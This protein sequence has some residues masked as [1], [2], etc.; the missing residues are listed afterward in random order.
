MNSASQNSTAAPEFHPFPNIPPELTALNQWV[1]WHYETR[2]G[3]QTK[4]P[5]DAK[6]NGKLLHAKSNDPA[7]WTTF[8]DAVAASAR[9][10][11]P[12]IGLCLSESDGL[13][14]LDLDHVFD[15]DT[16]ELTPFAKE[17][18]ERFSGTYCEISPSGTGIRVWCKGKPQRSGKCTG[19]VKWLEVYSHPSNRYLTVTG[20]QWPGTVIAVTQQQDALDWLHDR[21]MGKE[22]STGGDQKKGKPHSPSVDPSPDLPDGEL[23]NMARNAKNGALFETLW[24]GDISGHGNDP[25]VADFALL[26]I[27]A[28][29][30]RKDAAQMDRLFRQSGLMRDK[31]D[32]VRYA[33][34]RTYGQVSIDRAIAGCKEVYSGKKRR[35]NNA[36]KPAAGSK[37]RGMEDEAFTAGP[38]AL[39]VDG[40]KLCKHNEAAAL[41][42]EKEF[43]GRLFYDPIQLDWFEYKPAA[44]IFDKRPGLA[45]EKA[46]Y[47]AINAHCGPLGFD[48]SYVSG[49]T[50]CLLYEAITEPKPVVGKICFT[51]GVLDLATRELLPHSPSFYFTSSLPFAWNPDAP[52]PQLVI[53]WLSTS[54]DGHDDQV[55]LLRAFLNAVVVGRPDLQRFL[56]LIGAAGSGKGSFIRLAQALVGS[57][58]SHSTRLKELEENRFETANLLGKRLVVIGDAEKWHGS[59]DVLKS[60]TGEDSI[61]FEQ[62]HKQGGED[63]IYG[64]MVIIAGNQHTDS[65][66]YSSGIQRRKITV[67]FDRA[68][69]SSARRDLAAEFEPLLP[70][71]LKWVLDMPQA[72]V[73]ARLRNTSA[74]TASL[75]AARL[76]ALAATNPMVAWMLDNVHFAE[77]VSAQVGEKKRITVSEGRND[78]DHTTMTHVE[79]EHEDTRL[80]PNYCQWCDRNG[81]Q[82]VSKNQF[83]TTVVDAAK[84]LLGKPYVERYRSSEG[85]RCIRGV[86]LNPTEEKSKPTTSD[87]HRQ[88]TDDLLTTQVIDSDEGIYLEGFSEVFSSADEMDDAESAQQ[89]ALGSSPDGNV[90]NVDAVFYG[91]SQKNPSRSSVHQNQEVRLSEVVSGSSEV[92]S[93]SSVGR[94]MTGDVAEL[95][96]VLG[97]FRGWVTE[98]EVATKAGWSP[99]KTAAALA[100]LVAAGLAKQSGTLVKPANPDARH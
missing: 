45:I 73:T 43:G 86:E 64:G 22:E 83:S 54:V 84:N 23:L 59:V 94:Q 32:E 78:G 36:F 35:P 56:E 7:T 2:N 91:K 4:P 44:G 37:S 19:K 53:D 41:L 61:R 70:A 75:K 10:C 47:Q 38:D 1:C 80:Y 93:G 98:N 76:D 49:V 13:T 52:P 87:N 27:L 26:C 11:L 31:W 51:N 9:L 62:K 67:P 58:G 68:V 40:E 95:A 16:G 77:N 24:R 33:D 81:K 65:N 97:G 50:K 85:A 55:Q 30:T 90:E 69:P 63:F 21:F 6:S 39:L 72:E 89:G 57:G 8:D 48:T 46:V 15:P 96:T 29:W 66:D 5:I 82:P 25:S 92:V 20:R 3:K 18:L 17:V 71:V 14:G 12:G 34:G 99:A 79:Y 88:P 60:I 42:F 28:F 74:H 100:E